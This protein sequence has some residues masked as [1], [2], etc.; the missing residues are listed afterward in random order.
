[1]IRSAGLVVSD[2][3]LERMDVADFGLGNLYREGAQIVSLFDTPKLAA[4]IIV[5]FPNQAEPEHWHISSRETE[6]KEETLRIIQG[7]LY[8]YLPG[9]NTAVSTIPAGKESWYTSR[10]EIILNS[11][12]TITIQPG[13]KHWFCAGSE[14]VVFYTMSTTASDTTDIFSDPEI[15]RKTIISD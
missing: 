9:G 7:K 14:G 5:L 4:R 10:N 1:M 3:E 15:V 8:L 13:V 6:G 11:C 12:E 2:E